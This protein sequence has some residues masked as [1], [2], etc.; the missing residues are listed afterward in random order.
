MIYCLVTLNV[1]DEKFIYIWIMFQAYIKYAV[2]SPL[3][4]FR[5]FFF[6]TEMIP[7]GGIYCSEVEH[8]CSIDK[9]L[10]LNHGTCETRQVTSSCKILA[11][12]TLKLLPVECCHRMALKIR[13]SDSDTG[14]TSEPSTRHIH[15]CKEPCSTSFGSP[16][17]IS[18]PCDV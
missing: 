2:I 14:Q 7:R 8:L 18:D 9:L 1:S 13:A 12:L 6:L 10:D 3:D 11:G 16:P 4:A 5:T 15:F 17:F